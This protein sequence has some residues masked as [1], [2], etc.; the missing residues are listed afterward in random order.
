[1]ETSERLRHYLSQFHHKYPD[2]W[3]LFDEFRALKNSTEGFNCPDW[4]F[5]PLGAAYA[6][7]SKSGRMSLN[8][9][10]DVGI[11]GGL[12]A[13]RATQGIYR[14]DETVFE[15]VWQ[16]R[17]SGKL[18]VEVL[19]RLPEWCVYIETPGK[20]FG[21]SELKGF[22]V[23][24]NYDRPHRRDELWFILDTDD[25]LTSFPLYLSKSTILDSLRDV[26]EGLSFQGRKIGIDPLYHLDT[27]YEV[28]SEIEPLISLTLYLCS[29][30]SEIPEFDNRPGINFHSKQRRIY[31]PANPQT[32]NVAFRLGAAIRHAAYQEKKIGLSRHQRHRPRPHIRRAH[33]ATYWT[34]KKNT[35]QKA[36]LK[37]LPPIAIN[38]T[39]ENPI[40]PTSKKID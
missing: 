18:P 8:L 34:G 24:M 10:P 29:Q 5:C 12:A 22:F 38:V 6:I 25:D 33:W 23:Y 21:D 32:W 1:M 7:I 19:Y 16:T 27:L 15:A 39:L 31:P 37:W 3:K 35:T 28:K 9:S 30:L 4:C 13:W 36:L 11:L 14:F 40:I 2:A 26:T 20:I 17:I